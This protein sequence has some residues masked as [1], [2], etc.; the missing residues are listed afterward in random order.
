MHVKYPRTD[1]VWNVLLCSVEGGGGE[2]D[3][4]GR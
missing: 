2:A 1:G 3:W 4:S